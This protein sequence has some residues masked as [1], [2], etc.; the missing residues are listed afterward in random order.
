MKDDPNQVPKITQFHRCYEP[1]FD[2]LWQNDFEE[3]LRKRTE[4][5]MIDL[6]TIFD[7]LKEK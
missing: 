3:D 4:T 1:D 6:E 5:T 7:E 2:Y